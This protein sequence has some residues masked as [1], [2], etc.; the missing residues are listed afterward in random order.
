MGIH[1]HISQSMSQIRIFRPNVARTTD[2]ITK[3]TK[4][5]SICGY[6]YGKMS[7]N[8]WRNK[9]LAVTQFYPLTHF[10]IWP[11]ATYTHTVYTP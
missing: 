9:S 10:R 6:L 7:G 8:D 11:V 1:T 3:S 4:A 2:V 5:K